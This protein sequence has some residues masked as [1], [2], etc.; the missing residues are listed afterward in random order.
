[1]IYTIKQKNKTIGLRH[2]DRSYI[3]GFSK[4]IVARNVHYKMSPEPNFILIKNNTII[5]DE[6]I[7]DNKSTLFIPKC[8]GSILDPMND[9]GFHLSQ[10][11]KEDFYILPKQG[12]GIILPYTMEEENDLEFMFKVH[13]FDPI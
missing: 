3:I 9:G 12:V 5:H 2:N 7:F 4:L 10:M 13:V 1:M 8:S 6:I 11:K